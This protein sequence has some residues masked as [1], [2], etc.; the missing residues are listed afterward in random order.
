MMPGTGWTVYRE[1]WE[2]LLASRSGITEVPPERWDWRTVIG[3]PE[4]EPNKTNSKWGGFVADIDC[5]DPLFFGM[6]PRQAGY[7]DP[8][9]RIALE[10]AWHAIEDAGYAAPDLA[11]RK[12]GVYVGVSKND[13]A[14]LMREHQV[15]IPSFVSTG[16]V[17]SIIANRISFQ[18]DLRAKSAVV[19]TA[20]SSSLVALHDAIRDLRLGECEMALVGGVNALLSP[21]MFIAHAQSG[22]LASD[23]RC[24]VF[25]ARANGYVR[26]EGVAFVLLKPL[27]C[28]VEDGDQVIGVIKGSAVNHGGRGNSLTTPSVH[29][30]AEVV[31][32]ALA[33]AAV[34]ASSIGYVEAHGTGT[35]LG[36]PIEIRALT[37]A[38]SA[39]GSPRRR[40]TCPVGAV[41]TNIGHLESASGMA[42][43]IKVLLC[44]QHRQ[45]PP[46]LHFEKLNPYVELE[47]TP[48]CVV[49]ERLEWN[50]PDGVPRRAG[51]S[52]F[53]MGG[54]NAH[55]IVEEAPAAPG[56]IPLSAKTEAALE[57]MRIQLRAF[58]RGPGAGL[59]ID[60]VAFTLQVGRETFPHRA[61][62]VAGGI[63]ELIERLNLVEEPGIVFRGRAGKVPAAQAE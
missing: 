3:D 41:K 43:L 22:M 35:A 46:S 57:R 24:K 47:G 34:D 39:S 32:A 60:D 37:R 2:N 48:F 10:S 58:L 28:A 27:A 9:Q 5:F 23:G 21:T 1:F 44:L 13:Y 29:A 31:A 42:A 49:R 38:F 8:Q 26:G 4:T 56:V 53:G 25:D 52:A 20:C 55:V 59:D 40:A 30:Q 36:D 14:E 19:D 45:I 61:A 6:S 33:D 51:L 63:D 15:S 12:V 54:V 17:H 7:L 18:L 16:T 11:G 62:W 50:E